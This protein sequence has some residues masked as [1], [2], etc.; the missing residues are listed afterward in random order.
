MSPVVT[1]QKKAAIFTELLSRHVSDVT[2]KFILLLNAKDREGGI[3]EIIAQFFRLRDELMGIA[4]VKAKSVVPFTDS[5]S[6]DLVRQ[7][8]RMTKKTV[9]V[10]YALDPWLMGG[11]IVQHGDTV[12]DASVKH[13]LE[14]DNE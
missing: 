3:Q 5:Q 6:K 13:Q 2:M 9:K 10:D 11:F 12:W 7:L 8:E 1:K 14:V 4:R